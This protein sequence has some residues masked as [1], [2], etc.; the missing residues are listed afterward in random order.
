[1]GFRCGIV[2]LPNVGKSTLFNAL[3]ESTVAAEN[4]P[5]CTIEPNVGD[6]LVPDKRL[7]K[8]SALLRPQRTLQARVK[9]VDI[10]GLVSGASQG[11]GLGN[12]FLAQLR[13]TQAIAHVVRC[14]E[15]STVDHV[16]GS[17]DPEEDVELIHTELCLADLETLERATE[18]LRRRSRAGEKAVR[19]D[20]KILER[21]ADSLKQA[22]PLRALDYDK[23]ERATLE[24]LQPLTLKPMFYIANVDE[25]GLRHSSH[26][27][28]L[29]QHAQKEHTTVLPICAKV[30]AELLELPVGE[31]KEYLRGIGLEESGLERVAH[32]GYQ[33]LGLQTFF[34]AGP[35]EVRAWTLPQGATALQAAAVIHSDFARGFICAEVTS[36]EDYL[37]C[38]GEQQARTAGKLRRESRDYLIRDGDVVLFRF[39]VSSGSSQAA[40][41]AS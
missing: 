6:I 7:E 39:H 4:Y 37:A 13:E 16:S 10:A 20:L 11:D 14:F 29:E 33:L 17:V 21:A 30:E 9:F 5:F 41:K 36:C 12:R 2:G 19:C 27:A 28:S 23:A 32:A 24:T 31:R 25:E 35:Q 8:L 15:D 40:S 26:Y 22:R 1:M 18:K 3:T 38:G 34:T